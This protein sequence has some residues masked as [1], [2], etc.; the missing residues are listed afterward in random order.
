ML[1]GVKVMTSGDIQVGYASKNQSFE[2]LGMV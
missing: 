1:I 2:S